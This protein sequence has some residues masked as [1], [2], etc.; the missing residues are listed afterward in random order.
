MYDLD[1]QDT[2]STLRV[3]VDLYKEIWADSGKWEENLSKM[4]RLLIELLAVYP[5]DTRALTNLGAVLSDNGKHKEALSELLK[6]EKLNAKD[7]NL[8]SNI[9]IAKMNIGLERKSAKEYFEMAKT[10]KKDQLTIEAY[11]DLHGY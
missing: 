5:N 7:A 8:Y 2:D 9:A 11:F 4:E 10:L 1:F 3:V 6:S